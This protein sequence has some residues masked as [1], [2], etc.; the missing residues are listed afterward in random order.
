MCGLFGVFNAPEVNGRSAKNRESFLDAAAY[1]SALRGTDGTGFCTANDKGSQI[2][3]DPI[4]PWNFIQTYQ[5][6][7]VVKA[8]ADHNIIIGHSRS[9]TIGGSSHA[10]TH[11]FQANHITL[12]HNG[13]L[14]NMYQLPNYVAGIT[15]S[16][17]IAINMSKLGEKETLELLEG[18]YA[19]TWHN[20][21]KGT[22]NIARNDLRTLSTAM[23][24]EKQVLYYM[25][26]S[27]M[28][29]FALY[30]A[31]IKTNQKFGVRSVVS[32]VWY[33]F[34]DKVNRWQEQKFTVKK[35][36][37]VKYQHWAPDHSGKW[38]PRGT[39]TPTAPTNFN[40]H[41]SAAAA[42]DQK[43][44]LV[45]TKKSMLFKEGDKVL[46]E[47]DNY[48]NSA[49]GITIV[50]CTAIDESVRV[51]AGKQDMD[52]KT[53]GTYYEAAVI[54]KSTKNGK[55]TLFVDKLIAV[56]DDSAP[57]NSTKKE[58]VCGYCDAPIPRHQEDLA[59]KVG[60]TLVGVCCK[61]FVS[62]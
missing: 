11:P 50:G 62:D 57:T 51:I 24:D 60:E 29:R 56:T 16:E 38:G 59:V 18:P 28:L 31:N 32:G 44:V 55:V 1:L 17:L 49:K 52:P 3:K 20:K 2:Y 22:F 25:S 19:L 42:V 46:I 9:K 33:V 39:I 4:A 23:D 14:N 10:N 40:H 47:V 41:R 61:D 21:E 58:Q 13:T 37:V 7:S 43:A 8:L 30:H 36:E 35:T 6:Q 15:D 53:V 26:D 5:Y 54:G 34:S 45:V 48:Y 27:E 12:A